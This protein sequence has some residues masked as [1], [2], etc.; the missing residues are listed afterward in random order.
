MKRSLSA[1]AVLAL[2]ALL[3]PA[4]VADQPPGTVSEVSGKV[5]KADDKTLSIQT[6]RP[7][8]QF[9]EAITFQIT[10]TTR[11]TKLRLT[12]TKTGDPKMPE[13]LVA[14]QVQA[15]PKDFEK[16]QMISAIY[17]TTGQ[18]GGKDVNVLLSAVIQPAK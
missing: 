3:S 14:A 15:T 17:T 7:G 13:K 1:A 6:R 4:G 16:D 9:G 11:V 12:L 10:D 8:G 5:I 2:V 18:A